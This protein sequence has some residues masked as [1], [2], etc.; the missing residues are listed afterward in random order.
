MERRQERNT[1]ESSWKP[2]LRR[3]GFSVILGLVLLA[4]LLAAAAAICLRLDLAQAL[5]P[6]AAIPLGGLSAFAA[7]FFNVSA[8]RRQGLLM[9]VFTAAGLYVCVLAGAVAASQAGIGLN[10][11]VLLLV[12]LF[13][14]AAGGVFAANRVSTSGPKHRRAKTGRRSADNTRKNKP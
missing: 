4:G 13:A 5:L 14:G 8:M 11:V 9:G 7:A 10:A 3:L 12:M 2:V 6:M 1:R